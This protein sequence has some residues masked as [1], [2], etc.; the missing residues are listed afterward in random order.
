M[1][2]LR[3]AQLESVGFVWRAGEHQWDEMFS[4]LCK[5]VQKYGHVNVPMGTEASTGFPGLGTWVSS[6]RTAWKNMELF[7]A[8]RTPKSTAR[9]SKEQV[10]RLDKMGFEWSGMRGRQWE[11]MWKHLEAFVKKYGN[12]HVPWNSSSF[13]GFETL[14]QWVQ[15]QRKQHL[16]GLLSAQRMTRLES[17]GLVWTAVRPNP[18]LQKQREDAKKPCVWPDIL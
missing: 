11:W 3:V 9:I 7:T 4:L 2:P 8:G 10:A 15:L 18:N 5:Y 14:E 1:T 17:L 16:R 12:A 13:P 6:Q